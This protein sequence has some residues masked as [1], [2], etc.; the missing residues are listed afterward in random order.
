LQP[1]K[2][3]LKLFRRTTFCFL[4]CKI[5]PMMFWIDLYF[6][7]YNTFLFYMTKNKFNLSRYNWS[8]GVFAYLK[9]LILHNQQVEVQFSIPLLFRYK[10]ISWSRFIHHKLEFS[11]S[12]FVIYFIVGFGIVSLGIHIIMDNKIDLFCY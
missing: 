11:L 12:E 10:V 1:N 9:F 5:Q 8:F 2:S 4:C 7:W 6:A 3:P